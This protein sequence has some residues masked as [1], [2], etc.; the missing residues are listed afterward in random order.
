MCD[1]PGTELQV[2]VMGELKEAKV[3]D[4][5]PVL[6]QPVR[7]A[8]EKKQGEAKRQTKHAWFFYLSFLYTFSYL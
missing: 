4:G 2:E 6:T 3:L 7:D 5:P 1:I 8:N